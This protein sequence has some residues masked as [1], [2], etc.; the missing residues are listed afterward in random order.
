M[1]GTLKVL[2]FD[3]GGTT[4]YVINN[5]HKPGSTPPTY[6]YQESW[7]G[8]QLGPHEHHKELWELL[9]SCDANIIVCEAFN[10]RIIKNRGVDQPGVVLQSRNYIGIIELYVAL[11]RKP[12]VMQPPSVIGLDWV[13][14]EALKAMRIYTAGQK[15]RNDATRHAVYHLVHTLKRREILTPL[16]K[17]IK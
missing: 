3:P 5:V 13:S 11:T 15:H 10:Y 6:D 14:D 2:T 1:G 7:S 8:G 16:R 9:T 4:G 17:L 12:L